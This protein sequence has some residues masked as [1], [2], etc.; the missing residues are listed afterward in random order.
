[1]STKGMGIL[2]RNTDLEG[3]TSISVYIYDNIVRLLGRRECH[4]FSHLEMAPVEHIH[5]TTSCPTDPVCSEVCSEILD[6]QLL[7]NVHVKESA[8]IL[9]QGVITGLPSIAKAMHGGFPQPL[10]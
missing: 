3:A 8:V 4:W 9:D 7:R 2:P 1:M 6:R 10:F 5:T